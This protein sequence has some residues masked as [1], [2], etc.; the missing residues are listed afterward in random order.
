MS[1]GDE[2]D[3]DF[4]L[5]DPPT[6]DEIDAKLSAAKERLMKAQQRHEA[7]K[8]QGPLD[9]E[10]SRGMGHGLSAAYAIIGLPLVGAGLGWLADRAL[11]TTFFIAAG[12]VLGLVG[13][14]FHAVQLSNR[15]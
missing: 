12:A 5:P 9:R 8:P 7:S 2:R 15:A 14:M 10:T 3:D 13:A 4:D 6:E 11:G 1:N